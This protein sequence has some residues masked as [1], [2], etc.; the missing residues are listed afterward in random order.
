[1]VLGHVFV[2]FVFTWPSSNAFQMKRW[3]NKTEPALK[4]DVGDKNQF[5]IYQKGSN[6]NECYE[7]VKDWFGL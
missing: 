6:P 1:M 4:Q 3:Q 2:P 5:K 7:A